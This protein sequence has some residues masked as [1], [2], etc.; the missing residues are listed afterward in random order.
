[1]T[2]ANIEFDELDTNFVLNIS[3]LGNNN[4]NNKIQNDEDTVCLVKKAL[5]TLEATSIFFRYLCQKAK[6]CSVKYSVKLIIFGI[7]RNFAYLTVKILDYNDV[8]EIVMSVML[9]F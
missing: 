3:V 2:T 1:M 8:N 9:S 7:Q 4:N 6:N 5:M